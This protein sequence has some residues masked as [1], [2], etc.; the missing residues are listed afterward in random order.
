[1]SYSRDFIVE[2]NN[3]FPKDRAYRKKYKIAF[4]SPEHRALNQI[5]V[6]LDVLEDEIY[7]KYINQYIKEQ[8]AIKEYKEK[9][10]W[11]KE[12]ELGEKKFTELFDSLDVTKMN[13]NG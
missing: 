3:R 9:G 8:E 1:M 2:W 4:G 7:D 10:I 11:L 6:Y 5:D 13:D 12:S